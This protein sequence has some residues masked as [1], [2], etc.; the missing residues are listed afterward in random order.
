MNKYNEG[1][2]VE[3]KV[4]GIENY[5]IFLSFDDG[6]SGL[7]HISEISDDFVKDVNSFAKIGDTIT[8]K[9][10]DMQDA[11]H[12]KLSIKEL[13]EK[14]HNRDNSIKETSSGFNTLKNKLNEWVDDFYK[15]KKKKL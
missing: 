6:S 15:K 13:S 11:S 9:I 12:Y 8:V 4:T 7:V 14:K 1:D 2:I 5:G 3:G 10:L